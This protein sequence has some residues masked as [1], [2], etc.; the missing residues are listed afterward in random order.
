MSAKIPD[1]WEDVLVNFEKQIGNDDLKALLH[2]RHGEPRIQLLS[3]ILDS[4][5]RQKAQCMDKRWKFYY[6]GHDLNLHGILEKSAL[7]IQRFI[8][9]GDVC[10]Q[11]DPTHA[12]IPWALVRFTL[13]VTINDFEAMVSLAEGTEVVTGLI[14]RYTLYEV[15]YLRYAST[16]RLELEKAIKRVYTEVL[17]YL[18]RA[19]RYYGKSTASA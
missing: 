4:V 10:V 3:S 19:H 6:R 1:L 8:Q 16:V 15:I 12:S 5:Q 13:Q 18:L 9:I 2:S 17:V 11:Y 14:T 7:W